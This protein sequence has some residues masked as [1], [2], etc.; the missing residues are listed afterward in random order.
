MK[1][2]GPEKNGTGLLFYECPASDLL[3]FYFPDLP[4]IVHF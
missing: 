3:Q 1:E 4:A 2:S